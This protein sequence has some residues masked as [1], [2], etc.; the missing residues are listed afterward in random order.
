M[1]KEAYDDE[2]IP[3]VAEVGGGVSAMKVKNVSFVVTL[4]KQ[5]AQDVKPAKS[6]PVKDG[7]PRNATYDFKEAVPDDKDFYDLTF[8]ASIVAPSGATIKHEGGEKIRVWPSQTEIKFTSDDAEHKKK[9]QFKFIA[10]GRQAGL[11]T[12]E[13][14][15]IWKAR[16]PRKSYVVE[17]IPPWTIVSTTQGAGRKREYKVAK[18]TDKVRLVSPDPGKDVYQIVN[19]TAGAVDYDNAKTEKWSRE[20]PYGNVLEVVVE[21]VKKT[22]RQNDV[23]YIKCV[24]GRE[25]VRTTPV[26]EIL[27]DGGVENIVKTNG[28]KTQTARVKLDAELRAK[29]KVQL[30]KAGG[31]TCQIKVGMTDACDDGP[32]STIK[33]ENTRLIW[34]QM[35][36]PASFEPDMKAAVKA[37]QKVKVD[38]KQSDLNSQDEPPAADHQTWYPADKIITGGTGMFFVCGSH[39]IDDVMASFANALRA[40]ECR[41]IFCHMQ[42]DGV[43]APSVAEH[44]IQPGAGATVDVSPLKSVDPDDDPVLLPRALT[45][46][47]FAVTAQW[48]T[49]VV[50]SAWTAIPEAN[51]DINY[52]TRPNVARITLPAGAKAVTD[53][54]AR[55]RIQTTAKYAVGP[56][57]GWAPDGAVVIAIRNPQVRP[58]AEWNKTIVHEVGHLMRMVMNVTT[59]GLDIATH[60]RAHGNAR[61]GL[62][63]HCADGVSQTN[64]DSGGKVQSAWNPTCVMFY[65]GRDEKKVEFCTRCTP[66]VLG[67]DLAT[68]G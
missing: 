41:L 39:N 60:G 30:G 51:I 3:L 22:A 40:R 2:N 10:D 12:A 44:V 56:Y 67:E 31:D 23:V 26:P 8:T 11:G 33:I 50:G 15:G 46:G 7:F 16:A 49:A 48:R 5:G 59:P 53:G 42:F 4:D 14:S 17:T 47:A 19:C 61:G 32:D 13:D 64:W 54:G 45:D 21:A 1:P 65:A 28:D 25:S 43:A 66:F 20:K 57:N 52:P 34:Y 62:G 36:R 27:T 29:F 35:G 24:F 63:T 6:V 38:F 18:V 58:A 37:L 68:L 55:I 9:V